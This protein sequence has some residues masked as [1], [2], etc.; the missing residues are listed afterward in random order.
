MP[1]YRTPG[2]YI[3]EIS[4]GPRPVAASATT[5]TG[6]VAVL[7]LPESFVP[8][9]GAAAGMFLPAVEDQIRLAWNRVL[10]FRRYTL[11]RLRRIALD[12]M[13][14]RRCAGWLLRQPKI[15]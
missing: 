9:Q 13:L 7:T 5:D 12:R 1:E 10:A 3:E 11:W 4:G 14:W 15:V 2:V 8:G 6:F